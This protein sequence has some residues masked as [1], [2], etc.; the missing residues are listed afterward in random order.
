MKI[1]NHTTQYSCIMKLKWVGRAAEILFRFDTACIYTHTAGDVY[2]YPTYAD[3]SDSTT[4]D[5]W[6]NNAQADHVTSCQL[7]FLR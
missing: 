1:Y 3:Y 7:A 6:F 5:V 2:T 4:Q